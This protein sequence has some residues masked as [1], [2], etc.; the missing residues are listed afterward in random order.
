[1]PTNPSFPVDVYLKNNLR[2]GERSNP[3]VLKRATLSIKEKRVLSG[4]FLT[5]GRFTKCQKKNPIS[6]RRYTY[7][8]KDTH[9]WSGMR[10]ANIYRDRA[11]APRT[12]R[13]SLVKTPLHPSANLL[14]THKVQYIHSAVATCNIYRWRVLPDWNAQNHYP[15][16]ILV[17]DIVYTFSNYYYNNDLR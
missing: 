1:M 14:C 17:G 15:R 4:L 13:V 16:T 12:Y 5:G 7:I 11:Y 8:E 9:M 6:G 2:R 3:R 10:C